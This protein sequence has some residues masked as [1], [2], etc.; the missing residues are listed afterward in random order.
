MITGA[1]ASG[2]S[3]SEN[4]TDVQEA[5]VGKSATQMIQVIGHHPVSLIEDWHP[6]LIDSLWHGD[7]NSRTYVQR[8]RDIGKW[9]CSG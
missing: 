1:G 4:V 6:P 8:L 7:I 3:N 5:A 9:G 2:M